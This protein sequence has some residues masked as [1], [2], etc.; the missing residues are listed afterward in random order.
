MSESRSITAAAGFELQ[1]D[2]AE[3]SGHSLYLSGPC[4]DGAAAVQCSLKALVTSQQRYVAN[5]LLCKEDLAAAAV[6]LPRLGHKPFHRG[7]TKLME[8]FTQC[9]PLESWCVVQVFTCV[10]VKACVT[11]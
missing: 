11:G 4:V 10:R 9:K 5:N 7:L 3:T 1:R 2:Y 6:E 8:Q